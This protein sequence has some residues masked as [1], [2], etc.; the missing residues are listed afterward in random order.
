MLLL[1]ALHTGQDAAHILEGPDHSRY[2]VLRVD[3]VLQHRATLV[4]VLLQRGEDIL[5]R[6]LALADDTLALRDFHVREILQV[7]VEQA[8]RSSC[9][10]DGFDN[11]CSRARRVPNV[12]AQAY[13]FI[14]VLH[15]VEYT[16]R[17]GEMLVL[18]AM[19][20]NREPDVELLRKL[21]DFWQGLV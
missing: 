1:P 2:W 18:R 19:I 14:H 5:D 9:N 11:V 12:D 10:V 17:R 20:V 13:T 8:A 21:L 15:G 4:V 6:H 16:L 3:L 7:H